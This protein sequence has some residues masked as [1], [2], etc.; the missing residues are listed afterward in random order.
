MSLIGDLRILFHM[1]TAQTGSGSDHKDRLEAFYRGQR[2]AYDDFRKRLLH[3]RERLMQSLPLPEKGGVLLD[4]GGGTG[5]NI[6]ALGERIHSLDQIEIVDL[7]ESL[8][9]I[10][11]E[12]IESNQWSNVSATCADATKYSPT[13]SPDAVTFSYSLT[14]I[15][16]WFTVID[17]AYEALKPGGIIGVVDFYVS[18]KWPDNGMKRHSAWTRGFWPAWFSYDNVFLSPEHLPYLMRKFHPILIEEWRGPVP[19]MP[20]MKAPY[21]LF[22]GRKLA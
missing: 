6:E 16:D 4:M 22:V 9:E 11:K 8:L 2:K 17:K 5:S 12:R 14:M 20:A 21:Y 1:L 15:P 10:A 3:G 19:Y 18:R 7:C 13:K